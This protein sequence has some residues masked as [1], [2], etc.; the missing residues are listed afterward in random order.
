[1]LV[2]LN[3]ALKAWMKSE[4]REMFC[5]PGPLELG[6]AKMFEYAFARGWEA[7][8]SEVP[9]VTSGGGSYRQSPEHREKIRL[10]VLAAIAAKKAGATD[11][12]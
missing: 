2:K 1:M 4:D 8:M 12:D 9:A 11:A 6:D 3:E 10:G 5:S 7:A